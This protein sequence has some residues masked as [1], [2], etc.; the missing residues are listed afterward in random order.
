MSIERLLTAASAAFAIFAAGFWLWS[1]TPKLPEKF[2]S[3]YGAPPPQAAP[4]LAALRTQSRRN[5]WGAI[6]AALAAL[7]QAAIILL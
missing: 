1:T 7:C 5:A 4:L 2:T 6:C 3:P